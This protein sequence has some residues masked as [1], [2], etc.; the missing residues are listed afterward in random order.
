M[1]FIYYG[2]I[3]LFCI[4]ILMILTLQLYRRSKS[5]SA[6]GIAFNRLIWATVVLCLADM[7]A[8]ICHGMVFAGARVIIEISNMVFYESMV[9]ASY[10][11]MIYVDIKLGLMET[12]SRKKQFLYALP[13]LA[14]TLAVLL[15]PLTHWLFGFS[16]QNAYVRGEG[17]FIHWVVNWFYLLVPT[18]KTSVALVR[19]KDKVR[20]QRLRPLLYYIIA[21]LV[22]GVTQMLFYGVSSTQVGITI[23]ILMAYLL[24]QSEQVHTDALTGLNNRRGLDDYFADYVQRHAGEN[25]G[26]IM[27]DVN[28]FK[29]VN[30]KYGHLVG[31][32]ALADT[33]DVL[34]Q[35]CSQAA[36]H[37]FLCRYGGDEFLFVGSGCEQQDLVQ[38]GEMIS[39]QLEIK[40]KT[41]NRPYKLSVG[42]GTSCGSCSNAEDIKRLLSEAD[43]QMYREKRRIKTK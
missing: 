24:M 28:E 40:N 30:D 33:A 4:V 20:R 12:A 17:I 39:A 41:L 9:L 14:V 18:L 11:W 26:L 16:A 10:F 34:K 35:V 2:E 37:L 27:L 43:A 29:L 36:K 19:E 22:A 7:I 38:I 32:Q 25:M 23:S 5:L 13:M 1:Y 3:N 6:D 42:I 15:N 21:P 31:D 8:G